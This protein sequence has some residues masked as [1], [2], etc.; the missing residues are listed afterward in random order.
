VIDRKTH[1]VTDWPIGN[2]KANFPMALDEGDH[3]LF[4]GTRKP[5]RLGVIDTTTGK[6]V[7]S[8]PAAGDMDDLYYDDSRKRIYIPGGE[9]FISVYEQTDPDHYQ[10]IGKIQGA[11]GARTGVWYAKRDRLYV[12][13]PGRAN[14]GAEIWVFE[15]QD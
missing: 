7:A 3:R 2:L 12:A 9:G 1:K 14:Q 5:S 15:A 6:V 13:V 11:I 4:I 10:Q 8:L